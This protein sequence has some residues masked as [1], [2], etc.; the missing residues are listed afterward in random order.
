LNKKSKKLNKVD[1]KELIKEIVKRIQKTKYIIIAAGVATAVLFIFLFA[2]KPAT[3]TSKAT[4]FPLTSPSDNGISSSMLSGILG[5]SDAPK[6][7]SS[8]ATINIIELALSRSIREQVACTRL[9]QFQNKTIGELLIKEQNDQRSL[10]AKNIELPKDSVA[11]AVLG[12]E[13][14]KPAIN[15][16]MSKNGVLEL[17][18][19]STNLLYVS[20]V[21]YT[22]IDKL[23]TFYIDL[24]RQ[25]ASD[26]YNFTLSKIDSLQLVING[27]DKKAIGIQQSTMF[28]PPELLEY[29]IP[30]SNIS[31]EKSRVVRQRDM[32]INNRDEALWHLQKVTPIISVLDKPSAPFDVVKPSK[33]LF[34]IIGFIAGS[35]LTA[36]LVLSGLLYRYA[37]SEIYKA[38][39]G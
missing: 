28:A 7:F 35:M 9:L 29:N 21:S 19:T 34:L 27:V 37:K 32:F 25:K 8:E 36:F 2:N 10:F 20:P 15:A 1:T 6:S 13:L 26:D 18:F 33:M 14:L 11:L 23:S 17:Y 16:K 30:K 4:L 3:Y 38:V 22:L 39:F 5:L 24:K 31:A 12:S